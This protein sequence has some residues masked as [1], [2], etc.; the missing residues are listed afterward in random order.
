MDCSINDLISWFN[1]LSWLWQAFTWTIFYE[2]W[3]LIVKNM[4]RWDAW[5]FSLFRFIFHIGKRVVMFLYGLLLVILEYIFPWF[6]LHKEPNC[7]LEITRFRKDYFENPYWGSSP[8]KYLYK[9]KIKWF[10]W[11]K[12][13][14]DEW[15]YET[16]EMLLSSLRKNFWKYILYDN[17]SLY[18]T[19]T[20][21]AYIK[22]MSF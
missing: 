9:Y 16:K 8:S 2:T 19:T 20:Y 1:G 17:T 7:I 22:L 6:F 11:D 10:E 13:Y 3:I 21:N 5:K 18:E 4:F 12:K 15:Q 14:E